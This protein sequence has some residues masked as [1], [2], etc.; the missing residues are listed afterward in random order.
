MNH[1]KSHDLM[2]PQATARPSM[3]H[4]P[5]S[6]L[7]KRSALPTKS[8]SLATRHSPFVP[9]RRPA[10]FTL[11]ELL[12][13]IAII[14][15]LM[16]LGFSGI[17]G[18]MKTARKSEVRS[19]ANQI[20]LAVQ[21]Y[22]TEYGVYPTNMTKTD[23][24]FL[25]MMTGGTN[26][27]RRGLRFIEAPTK[28]TNSSGMVTPKGFYADGGQSNFNIVVDTNYDGKIR[29]PGQSADTAGSLAVYVTDPE[30]PN[31]FLGTW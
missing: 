20:K 6:T 18:A 22:Y 12:V 25:T 19:M 11:I 2:L 17:T 21:N 13:V 16:G 14:V 7:G 29:L 3:L 8:R 1:Q 5:G 30:N 27:N 4:A 24:A 10:A 28:F 15:I 31:K 26:G 23:S 9:G